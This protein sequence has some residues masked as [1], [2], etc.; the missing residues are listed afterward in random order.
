VAFDRMIMVWH[1][2]NETDED[3]RWKVSS[4]QVRLDQG[5][6]PRHCRIGRRP[7]RAW[8]PEN[9]EA[10]SCCCP[11]PSGLQSHCYLPVD[12]LGRGSPQSFK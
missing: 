5:K 9:P 7:T 8:E 3:G 6:R 11:G 4:C 10:P 2:S 1:R 12:S